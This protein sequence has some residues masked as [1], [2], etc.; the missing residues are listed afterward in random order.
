MQPDR[1]GEHLVGAVSE[2]DP[3]LLGHLLGSED[4][5]ELQDALVVIGRAM[6]HQ[7][8]LAEQVTVLAASGRPA[9]VE[10]IDRAARRIADPLPL[11]RALPEA[12]RGDHFA[13]DPDSYGGPDSGRSSGAS[14][15]ERLYDLGRG[16][17]E[18]PYS[19]SNPF[20]DSEPPPPAG[21]PYSPLDGPGRKEWDVEPPP[22]SAGSPVERAELA[23]RDAE[24]RATEAYETGN[25]VRAEQEF[26][27]GAAHF[28]APGVDERHGIRV[29]LARAAA[30]NDL[31]SYDAALTLIDDVVAR[32]RRAAERG[33]IQPDVLGRALDL[34]AAVLAQTGRTEA[35]ISYEYEASEILHAF[36]RRTPTVDARRDAAK[37]DS[38]LAGLLQGAGRVDGG[39][40][41]GAGGRVDVGGAHRGQR[42]RPQRRHLWSGA[43]GSCPHRRRPR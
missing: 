9:L 18:N 10:A 40:Q 37:I 30:L 2:R 17:G 43:A 21:L 26:R 4:V 39:G 38:N 34:H 42:T 11:Q 14:T 31:R 29:D 28:A 33:T 22:G 32:V 25:L 23:G 5:D 1:L 24:R 41:V 36:A 8:H 35:A 6:A 13:Y 12:R 3:D 19:S 15:P 7:N 16:V 20:H 27:L